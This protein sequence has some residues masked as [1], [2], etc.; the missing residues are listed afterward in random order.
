MSFA[1]RANWW[2]PPGTLTERSSPEG[3]EIKLR[4]GD[5]E[6]KWNLKHKDEAFAEEMLGLDTLD[7]PCGGARPEYDGER[8]RVDRAGDG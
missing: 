4:F 6:R 5:K 8:R 1:S 2:L 3:T 7:Y